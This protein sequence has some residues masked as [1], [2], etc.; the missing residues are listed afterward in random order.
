MH[1]VRFFPA[2]FARGR[3]AATIAALL[4]P[5]L[6]AAANDADEVTKLMQRGAYREA[7]VQADAQIAKK[8]R[9]ANMRFLKGVLLAQMERKQEAM[10]VF[11]AL[12]QDFP[13][14]A[15]PYNNLGV[16]LAGAGEFDKAREAL[17]RATQLSPGYATAHE[18]LGDL[19]A[20]LAALSYEKSTQSDAGNA[21]TKSKLTLA[22]N[23]TG[24]AFGAASPAAASAQATPAPATPAPAVAGKVAAP[25]PPAP[26]RATAEAASQAAGKAPALASAAPAALPPIAAAAPARGAAGSTGTSANTGTATPAASAAAP[27]AAAAQARPAD[28]A[29]GDEKAVVDALERWA[30]AW[31]ARNVPAYLSSYARD[32]Q[33]ADGSTLA[34][35]KASR[36]ARILDKEK[37]SV[38]VQQPTVTLEGRRAIVK[39]IQAYSAGSVRSTDVKEMVLVREGATWLI[40]AE[41]VTS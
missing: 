16:L 25:L 9:D 24:A 5:L 39:F 8:P 36:R 4:F 3:L 21:K 33:P 7:L 31:S 30:S 23:L 15:E 29:A 37:I 22:R 32:F 19:Y 34:Q 14:L 2:W 11:T 18:N 1:K 12:T 13:Q 6:A 10:A 17:A 38:R 40:Q 26:A 35:W 27:A 20:R 41:R 28:T